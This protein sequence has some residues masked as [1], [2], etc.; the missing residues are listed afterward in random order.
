MLYSLVSGTS[1]GQSKYNYYMESIG[2]EM[3]ITLHHLNLLLKPMVECIVVCG[4]GFDIL[5]IL[6]T[7]TIL[8]TIGR[9]FDCVTKNFAIEDL[10]DSC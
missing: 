4:G 6:S 10:Q 3:C 2:C 1:C 9:F 7:L 8:I 5:F